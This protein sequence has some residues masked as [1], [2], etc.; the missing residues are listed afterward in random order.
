MSDLSN[1]GAF[2]SARRPIARFLTG[3]FL[4][5]AAIVSAL[6]VGI[7][8]DAVALL[9]VTII[10]VLSLDVVTGLAAIPTLGQAAFFG[11][12]AYAAGYAA[13]WVGIG[14]VPGLVIG[15]AAGTV[16]ALATGALLLRTGGIRLVALTLIVAELCRAI[17]TALPLPPAVPTGAVFG[18]LP[19]EPKGGASMLYAAGV[20]VLLLVLMALAYAA[21][22]GLA[23][24]SLGESPK[25]AA[26]IGAPVGM[27]RLAAY[28]IGGGIAG[29]AGALHAQ[30][31]GL[32]GPEV[33]SLILSLE[34]VVM[35]MV[36]GGGRL[37]GAVLGAA[38]VLAPARLVTNDPGLQLA[39]VGAIGLVALLVPGG[40]AALSRPLQ[41][42]GGGR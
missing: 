32:I 38:V 31:T 10:L 5:G 33:F 18:L 35:L 11:A 25:R 27:R 9:A 12:G 17:A 15:I 23:L 40:F 19:L 1:D 14:P 36:G 42:L 2:A 20:L 13:I 37:W 39:I 34:A 28:S 21:P 6:A 7:R 24:R 8:P 16:L 4:I 30:T 26:A 41:R 22:I 3:V 29:L